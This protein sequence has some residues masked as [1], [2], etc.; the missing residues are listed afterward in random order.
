MGIQYSSLY[1]D[2]VVH[3]VGDYKEGYYIGIEEKNPGY[4]SVGERPF[5]GP[6]IWPAEGIYIIEVLIVAFATYHDF[7]LNMFCYLLD[8]LPGWRKIMEKFHTEALYVV[9]LVI[10][11]ICFDKSSSY[12]LWL[13]FCQT[14]FYFGIS[15]HHVKK[16]TIKETQKTSSKEID[17]KIYMVH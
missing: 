14:F 9:V 10:V 8:L 16:S 17:T 4:D 15:I 1:I 13:E 12:K 7:L 6:N 5:Y 3:L 11:Q 2:I